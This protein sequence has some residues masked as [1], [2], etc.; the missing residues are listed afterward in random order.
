MAKLRL[1][2]AARDVAGASA[3]RFAGPD[4]GA[5]LDRARSAYGPEFAAVVD[6]AAIWLN[7]VPAGP[8]DPVNDDDEVAVLP[9]VSGG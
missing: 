2:G 5:V 9:P 7:G 6:T 8:D 1:F 4:V 3:A